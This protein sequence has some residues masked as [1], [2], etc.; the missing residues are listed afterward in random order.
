MFP[1]N[2]MYTVLGRSLCKPCGERHLQAQPSQELPE[3]AVKAQQDPTVCAKCGADNGMLEWPTVAGA[4]L[5]DAC[6]RQ[7]VSRPYP[8]WIKLAMLAILTLAVVELARNWRLFQ[9]YFEIPR[10]GK[11]Y[12]EGR[13]EDAH[14]LMAAAAAHV[15]ELHHLATQE[16]FLGG[17]CLI[18][19]GKPA[20][21]IPLLSEALRDWPEKD[22]SAPAFFLLV[23]RIE[24]RM[25]Q[26]HSAEAVPLIQELKTRFPDGARTAD[27]LM[28]QAQIG[29]AFEAKDYD[30]FLAKAREAFQRDP[31]HPMSWAML[32]SALA[33][34]YAVTGEE[35]FKTQA[36]EALGKAR[37]MAGED[38][39]IAEYL[40]RIAHRLKSREIIDK[41]EYDRRFRAGA[42][43]GKP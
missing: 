15:P 42:K 11:A 38:K 25:A 26:D 35:S 30:R 12:H 18:R 3:G 36:T 22:G 31:D 2:E 7:Y 1:A 28:L 4:P 32:A 9:A 41:K 39:S 16:R 20:E 14:A 34:K 8:A 17:L 33:C 10:A 43:G 23:A 5:C 19:Q 13:I 37:A 40:E 21:A 29:A 6:R 24:D 27:D